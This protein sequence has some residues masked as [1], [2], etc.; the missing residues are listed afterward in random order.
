MAALVASG[1]W[2]QCREDLTGRQIVAVASGGVHAASALASGG[3]PAASALASGGAHAASSHPADSPAVRVVT[4]RPEPWGSPVAD[5]LV[6]EL[7]ADLTERY[8][9][10]S[11]DEIDHEMVDIDPAD[12]AEPRGAFLVAWLQVDGGDEQAVGCGAI[13]PSPFP[14][15]AEIKRM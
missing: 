5:E 9:E 10:A 15:A 4:V 12:V 6:A 3:V 8:G 13:R 1:A 7:G 11:A 2:R 14:D